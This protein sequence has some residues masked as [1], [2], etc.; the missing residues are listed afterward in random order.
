MTDEKY[1]LVI[2]VDS[3]DLGLDSPQVLIFDTGEAAETF[4]VNIL[5]L[6]GLYARSR[7]DGHYYDDDGGRYVSKAEVIEDFDLEHLGDCDG[8]QVVPAREGS[9]THD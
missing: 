4:A 2:R 6:A 1:A 3:I 7:E 8:F 5:V 9:Q